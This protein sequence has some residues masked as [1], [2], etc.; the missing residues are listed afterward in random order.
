MPQTSVSTVVTPA[1]HPDNVTTLPAYKSDDTRGLLNPAL[2][3]FQTAYAGIQKVYD[4]RTALL[5][6]RTRTPESVMLAVSEFAEKHQA[7]ITTKFDLAY[8]QCT[9]SISSIEKTLA[10]P[11]LEDA[12][13]KS[14]S[15]EVRAYCKGLSTE[16]R[17][18]TC[19]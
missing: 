9:T 18:G 8:A 1:L 7:A 4:A 16:E 13:R 12:E 2:V 14:I 5:V 3:A 6:D 10:A 11:V 17:F 19:Q 15:A